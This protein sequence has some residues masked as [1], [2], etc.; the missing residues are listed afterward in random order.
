M[1]K[2]S[3]VS[4][5][6]VCQEKKSPGRHYSFFDDFH[7]FLTKE[8]SIYRKFCNMSDYDVLENAID[9][10]MHRCF[11]NKS[12]QIKNESI[13]FDKLDSCDKVKIKHE[14]MKILKENVTPDNGCTE[15]AED[16]S[17]K[18]VSQLLHIFSSEQAGP[19]SKAC[20]IKALY[21]DIWMSHD[22]SDSGEEIEI[23]YEHNNIPVNSKNKF[24][25]EKSSNLNNIFSNLA[26]SISFCIA[27]IHSLRAE[28]RSARKIIGGVGWKLFVSTHLHKGPS[29]PE[30]SLSFYVQCCPNSYDDNWSVKANC[31]LSIY[32]HSNK[33]WRVGCQ[34]SNT[35]NSTYDDCGLIHF[36]KWKDLFKDEAYSLDG[37]VYLEATIDI[38]GP[39]KVTSFREYNSRL[40]TYSSIFDLQM[41]K[42]N[43]REAE[44]ICDMALK[45]CLKTDRKA[46]KHFEEKHSLIV[47]DR[48]VDTI[49]RLQQ[50]HPQNSDK[51]RLLKNMPSLKDFY[52]NEMFEKGDGM[53]GH[54]DVKVKDILLCTSEKVTKKEITIDKVEKNEKKES[55]EVDTDKTIRKKLVP[56]RKVCD[57]SSGQCGSIKV[58]KDCE[59]Q[60]YMLT[61]CYEIK[62]YIFSCAVYK[63]K[64]L[65]VMDDDSNG[66]NDKNEE[67]VNKES[68]VKFVKDN[69]LKG[70]FT[71]K[72]F[73]EKTI[74][75]L[76]LK[77]KAIEGEKKGKEEYSV[78]KLYYDKVNY[79]NFVAKRASIISHYLNN[80]SKTTPIET[81]KLLKQFCQNDVLINKNKLLS[82]IKDDA[83]AFYLRIIPLWIE[84]DDNSIA[85]QPLFL[86]FDKKYISTTIEV[87]FRS[88]N[89][90][91]NICGDKIKNEGIN[92]SCN[93]KEKYKES[94]NSVC[95]VPHSLIEL[96]KKILNLWDDEYS[97]FSHEMEK[98]QKKLVDENLSISKKYDE[99]MKEFNK[100]NEMFKSLSD[101]YSTKSKDISSFNEVKMKCEEYRKENENLTRNN[102]SIVDSKKKMAEELAYLKEQNKLLSSQ[103]QEK[104]TV[105]KKFKKTAEQEKSSLIK[106]NETLKT[107]CIRSELMYLKKNFSIG[108]KELYKVKKEAL[109]YINTLKDLLESIDEKYSNTIYGK[110]KEFE[111]YIC[112]ID[113]KI[114]SATSNH[115]IHTTLI[116]EGKSLSQIGKIKI[117][118]PKALPEKLNTKLFTKLDVVW[119]DNLSLQ[120][121]PT[122]NGKYCGKE[123][124]KKFSSSSIG[125]GGGCSRRRLSSSPTSD[126]FSCSSGESQKVKDVF[127]DCGYYIASV[128]PVSDENT[129]TTID[130]NNYI[131][132]ND[133]QKWTIYM[134]CHNGNYYEYSPI[135]EPIFETSKYP[136]TFD[137]FKLPRTFDNNQELLSNFGFIRSTSDFSLQEYDEIFSLRGESNSLMTTQNIKP[138][139]EDKPFYFD[140]HTYDIDKM[141]SDDYQTL[142]K[143]FCSSNSQKS[144]W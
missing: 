20:P 64:K 68:K 17:L 108:I 29:G 57:C 3:R 78:E 51:G 69:N 118:K 43:K 127:T 23:P 74:S 98:N 54:C 114:E 84:G 46:I 42:G 117:R 32:S 22:D 139:S 9:D 62:N 86:D 61:L 83:L 50:K 110:I 4:K 28:I 47:H 116:E 111:D 125:G 131:K 71:F 93:D 106:E 94:L 48:V 91:K 36:I 31:E 26:N 107:K 53:C 128:S 90:L 133:D 112:N 24:L 35:F 72:K 1:G 49:T 16:K 27:N 89:I 52:F 59:N 87:V 102:Q 12:L 33:C 44:E 6:S 143:A 18:W 73:E 2:K 119:C 5:I 103:L 124:K 11:P 88:M 70:N 144:D 135:D 55:G 21:E 40:K 105:I 41:S 34:F 113:K 120:K 13:D 101:D 122:Q 66:C 92:L 81:K 136:N 77:G 126:A 96:M 80:L 15:D 121:L 85:N 45:Y 39:I 60:Y 8:D 56:R 25:P 67:D 30:K 99:L 132:N 142:Y 82:A 115:K 75:K 76:D 7:S 138:L 79:F 129:L 58:C 141:P 109:E 95:I 14:M 130:A 37:R 100:V 134:N 10:V 104:D 140:K 38:K 137:I 97:K 65:F 123:K 63:K 19:S